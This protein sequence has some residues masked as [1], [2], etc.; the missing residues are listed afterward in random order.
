MGGKGP[1]F[2]SCLRGLPAA[3]RRGVCDALLQPGTAG[4]RP[5][6]YAIVACIVRRYLEVS[7]YVPAG[8]PDREP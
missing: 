6:R 3:K 8:C 1:G 7:G 5:R 2:R 4:N